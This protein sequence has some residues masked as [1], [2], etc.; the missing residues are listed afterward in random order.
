M[1]W[2]DIIYIY[3]DGIKEHAILMFIF[4]KF[5]GSIK[6]RKFYRKPKFKKHD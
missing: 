6:N 2:K 3:N 1:K 4:G 5:V